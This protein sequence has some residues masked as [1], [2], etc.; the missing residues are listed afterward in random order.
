MKSFVKQHS[1]H[2]S[3]STTTTGRYIKQT[4]PSIPTLVKDREGVF[5]GHLPDASN[6]HQ[7]EASFTLSSP[8]SSIVVIKPP[9]H[10]QDTFDTATS[11]DR[12]D[13]AFLDYDTTSPQQS[14]RLKSK[15]ILL[16][17]QHYDESLSSQQN[18]LTVSRTVRRKRSKSEL[19]PKMAEL[20][21]PVPVSTVLTD[22]ED[23]TPGQ[24]EFTVKE[25]TSKYRTS[26]RKAK[27]ITSSTM[28]KR[29][30]SLAE[31]SHQ[32][33]GGDSNPPPQSPRLFRRRKTS[34]FRGRNKG[35]N[36]QRTQSVPNELLTDTD[37]I[38]VPTADGLSPSELK[39][40]WSYFKEAINST[41]KSPRLTLKSPS[42]DDANNL[43]KMKGRFNDIIYGLKMEIAKSDDP[44]LFTK[45]YTEEYDWNNS[46]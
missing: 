21:Y 1:L 17:R 37:N 19:T 34:I 8:K 33:E 30:K 23:P 26:L 44:V 28:R 7:E 6:S 42:G 31:E 29:T 20:Y 39:P 15:S 38:S 13:S 16:N 2:V 24:E 45:V 40:S 9:L 4:N 10:R 22:T 43:F 27:K 36:I 35:N 25:R 32:R 18:N 3:T 11:S 14:P 41:L 5:V 46:E 12:D